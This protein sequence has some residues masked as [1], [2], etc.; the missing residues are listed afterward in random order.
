MVN[1]WPVP[2]G[3]I[4]APLKAAL[5]GGLVSMSEG[6]SVMHSTFATRWLLETGVEAHGPW[7]GRWASA[8]PRLGRAVLLKVSLSLLGTN[9]CLWDWRGECDL[10]G[11]AGAWT[12]PSW[13]GSQ[14]RVPAG[15]CPSPFLQSSFPKIRVLLAPLPISVYHL[16]IL[17]YAPLFFQKHTQNSKV[18][19]R[20]SFAVFRTFLHPGRLKPG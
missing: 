5:V 20:F 16:C 9:L 12:S 4:P 1:R 13:G 10:Q 8:A 14:S 15:I 17:E 6:W 19:L 3:Q 18:Y 7:A 11:P 2:D